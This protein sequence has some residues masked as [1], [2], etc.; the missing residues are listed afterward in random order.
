MAELERQVC[1]TANTLLQDK[2]QIKLLEAGCGSAS[3]IHFE[4]KVHAVG[5]D[6]S[7][8]ELEKNTAVREKIQGDIQDYVFPRDE[9]D[10]V[11]CWMVLEHL[12]RPKDALLNLSRTVKPQGLLILGFP[13][14]LSVKGIITKFTPFWFHE[15]FYKF[16]HYKSRHFPTFLRT[17]ILP[18][19]V[20]QFAEENGFSVELLKLVEGGVSKKVR[21]R[22]RIAD[23]A[24]SGI[25]MI[26]RFLSFGELQSPLLDNC[27]VVLRKR[28]QNA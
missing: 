25:D 28:E 7:I 2:K 3:H 19:N 11:I 27:G 10:V 20:V 24:F 18:K 15:Q 12:S 13:N 16:M 8:E 1:E 14:L 5:I 26:T 4:A 21:H 23:W 6:I 17:D 22:F 9:F